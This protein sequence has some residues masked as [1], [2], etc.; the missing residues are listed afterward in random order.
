[1][2]ARCPVHHNFL[3]VN[4]V[5]IVGKGTGYKQVKSVTVLKALLAAYL[6]LYITLCDGGLQL[7]WTNSAN[8]L[9]M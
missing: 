3:S 4:A 9:A 2:P 1:M 8:Y 7:C 6:Y 5:T